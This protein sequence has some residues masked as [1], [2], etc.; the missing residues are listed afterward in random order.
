MLLITIET[1][2]L[3]A[4][5]VTSSQWWLALWI[6]LVG[7]HYAATYRRAYGSREVLRAH[8]IVTL[9]APLCLVLLA[10]L[11]L[12]SPAGFA[13]FYFLAYVVWSGY[14][15]SGQS[16]G[17]AMLYPLRQ[18]QP[19]AR[20]EKRLLALPL[21]GSWIVSLCG[22]LRPSVESRNAAFEYVRNGLPALRMPDWALAVAL[23]ALV[24]SFAGP[25]V[26]A[27][28]RQRRGTPLPAQCYAV[29]LAQVLWFAWGLYDPFFAVLLVP[30]LH[31]M[32]Y[33]AITGWHHA[34]GRAGRPLLPVLFG[35]AAFLLVVGVA[36][37]LCLRSLE[38]DLLLLAA[39]LATLNLHHFLLDGRIWRLREAK[40]RQ[41]FVAAR[42]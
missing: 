31:A 16:L 2:S 13:P 28:A 5:G 9:A 24:A 34:R 38:S 35:Y 32:Q 11:A 30:A 4:P 26:V 6:A 1:L 20:W 22:F 41:S 42:E 25:V 17:V 12:R 15:Y 14:H 37:G 27:S 19:L 10:V 29:L 39:A 21:Y 7:P 3:L 18:G 8:P 40:L 36:S 23:G 33:L